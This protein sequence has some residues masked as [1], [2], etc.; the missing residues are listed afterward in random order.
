MSTTT[1]I[2]QQTSFDGMDN[3]TARETALAKVDAINLSAYARTRNALDGRVT[4][5][6]PY[7]THGITDV[8]EII[9][10]LGAKTTLNWEEKFIFE[11]GWREYFHHVWH[12]LND[13]I[14]REQRAPPA[15]QYTS[16]VP[17]DVLTATTGVAVIDAQIR[18]LYQVGYLHNHARMWLASYMVHMRKIDWRAGA[19]WMFGYLLDGDMASNT[20]SWQWVAG[21]WTGKPYLFNA[22]NVAK[23][24]PEFDCAGSVIDTS[25][26]AMDQI[27]RSNEALQS[28]PQI[29]RSLVA[30]APPPLLNALEAMP[31]AV[32]LGFTILDALPIDKPYSLCHPWAIKHAFYLNQP[33]VGLI[34]TEFHDHY[35][36]S[37][38]RWRFVLSAM[39]EITDTIF[40]FNSASS[41]APQVLL[42][43]TVVDT[44][45]PHYR[46]IMQQLAKHGATIVDAPR[47]FI[48]PEKCHRSFSSFWHSAKKESFPL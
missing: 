8:P 16:V 4:R 41:V 9:K 44:L 22:E 45:N 34:V 12:H 10:R 23:Y 18:S 2:N 35:R 13:D 37:E 43:H 7:I 24:A 15:T 20:L 38:A 21:T 36:W 27:A 42:P 11:L 17:D 28:A 14:W 31:I 29:R 46:L 5:L 32:A 3:L 40:I 26:E 39:R 1:H 33:T 6:S 30:A 25:Y 47:A 19:Q 48:N